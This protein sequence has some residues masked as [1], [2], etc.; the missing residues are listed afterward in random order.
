MIETHPTTEALEGFLLGQL[1]PIE[2]RDIARHL[3]EGCL[4]CQEATGT[5]WEPN[6]ELD[7]ELEILALAEA[8]SEDL[9]EGYDDVLDRVFQRVVIAESVIADQRAAAVRLFEELMQVSPERRRL[10]LGNSNRFRSRM[11]CERLIDFKRRYFL[12]SAIDYLLESPGNK[13]VTIVLD[14]TLITR[15]EP[16]VCKRFF[17]YFRFRFILID[18]T[19]APNDDLTFIQHL[20]LNINR[21]RHTR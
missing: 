13:N 14:E 10:L 16:A 18:D 4:E 7:E 15:F 21:C 9:S 5:L 19:R 11:L 1:S 2:M 8:G 20:D 6:E 17:V 3:L 12:P